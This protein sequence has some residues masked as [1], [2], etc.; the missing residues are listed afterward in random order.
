[1]FSRSALKS[2]CVSICGVKLWNRINAEQQ[3]R[4]NTKQLR[5]TFREMVF[6]TKS[7]TKC[8]YVVY[9]SVYA[10]VIMMIYI[11]G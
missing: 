3:Q 9:M 5:M 6:A 8:K 7:R 2:F 10:D 4:P 1:M 11:M